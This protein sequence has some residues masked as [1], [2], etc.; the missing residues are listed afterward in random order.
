MIEFT[1]QRAYRRFGSRYLERALFLGHQLALPVIV[2]GVGLASLYTEISTGEF[3]RVAIVGCGLHF[4]YGVVSVPVTRRLSQPVA[5]WLEGER[6][7]ESGIAAWR[8]A[9]SLPWEILRRELFSPTLGALLWSFNLV[10]ALYLAWELELPVHSAV[11]IYVGVM[12]YMSYYVALRFFGGERVVRPVLD[13]IATELPG[14]A[15]PAV[16]GLSLRARLLAALPAINVITAVVADGLVRRGDVNLGDLAV[17]VLIATAVAGTI[18]LV[19]T[20]LLADSITGPIA[21]LRRA[22]ERVKSGD[23][24]TRVHVVTTD[25]TGELARAFNDMTAGLAERERIRD[26]FGT[27][28]DQDVA[29]HILSEGTLLAGAEVDVTIMFLDIRDFTGF[30]ERATAPVVVSTLNRLFELVVPVIHE[31]GGHVDKFI[32]DGLLA[33]F[34][35]PRRRHDHA[36]QAVAAAL[37]I[38]HRVRGAFAGEIQVG[39]GLNSGTVVAGNV[40]GAG[41]LEFSVIGDAVNVAARVEAATRETGDT[42]LLAERTRELLR[43][44]GVELHERRGLALK[45][46]RNPVALYAPSRQETV[47]LVLNADDHLGVG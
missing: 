37:D 24:S 5:A 4:I 44:P 13:D 2:L 32:G 39:I 34:G 16:P 36:D 23:F 1:L 3:L 27:Y 17:V 45:G 46:K 26:A 41:R 31:R 43:S 30:A 15:P 40:G 18:S 42:V 47:E 25:E 33:V 38:D 10:W 29:E 12:V 7:E 9:A 20:L 21:E 28:V 22:T 8:A 11:L 6:T 19:L 35:A 14:Q